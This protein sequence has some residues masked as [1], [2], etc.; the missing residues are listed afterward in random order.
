MTRLSR[1]MNTMFAA[2]LMAAGLV[3]CDRAPAAGPSRVPNPVS[4]THRPQLHLTGLVVDG[5]DGPV[6]GAQI[7]ANDVSGRAAETVAD[8]A[9]AYAVTIDKQDSVAVTVS[10]DG[11]ESSLLYVWLS[12]AVAGSEVAR[13]LRLHEILRIRA[14]DSVEVSIV[15]G[16]PSCDDLE[17]WPCRRIRVVSPVAGRLTLEVPFSPAPFFNIIGPPPD[18]GSGW[19]LS[20]AVAAGSETVVDVML[21]GGLAKTTTLTTRLTPP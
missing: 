6:A 9:G 1:T 2:A 18:G 4:P 3:A 8:A 16:D 17:G 7:A 19:F 15:E 13:N 20:V 11:F 12:G 21:V 5:N 10:K 14:G